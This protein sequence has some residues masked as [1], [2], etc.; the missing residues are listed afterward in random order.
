MN[1]E[2]KD[3]KQQEEVKEQEIVGPVEYRRLLSPC[4]IDVKDT[5]HF[6]VDDL[7]YALGHT[8]SRNIAITGHFGS[9][10]SSVANTCIDEMGICDEVLR[11][12]M[13][14]FA[15]APEER[16]NHDEIEYKIVQHL[17]YKCDASRIPD[18]GF[19]RL[20]RPEDRDYR[21]PIVM[22]LCALACCIIAFEPAMLRINS[23]YD[24]YYRLLGDLA[25]WWVNLIA[26]IASIGYLFYFLFRVCV[27][28]VPRFDKFKN[29]KIEAKG[30][31]LEASKNTEVSVF[32]K[33]LDEIIYIIQ[34]NQ[35]NYIL[36]E[37]LDRLKDSDKLFLKIRELN[38]LINESEA[39]KKRDRVVRFIYAIRDDVFTRELR[40]KCFDYI[41]A[42]VPVVDHYNVT[43]YLIKEYKRKGLFKTID[44]AVME[45]LLSKVSGLRELKNIVNEYT[46]F[47]KSLRAHIG[48]GSDKYEQ[49]MLAVI[50]YKNIFPQ[51]F[52]KAYKKEGLFYSVFREKKQFYEDKTKGL[53]ERLATA[54]Q[55]MNEM[56]EKI[57]NTRKQYLETLNDGRTI[58]KLIKNG[59]D[60]TLEQVANRDNL[61]ELFRNN[62]FDKYTYIEDDR[63]TVG[64]S[65]YDFVFKELENKIT[66]D[67]GYDEAV[68]VD[69]EKYTKA[70][71]DR[72]NLEKEI[73]VI[74]NTSLSEL[75][76]DIGSKKTTEILNGI[77]KKEY[78]Q[79]DE[80]APNKVNSD[81]VD[82]LQGMLYGGY[83]TEDYY[84]YISMFYEGAT[85]ES[86]YQFRSSI[87]HGKEWPY[88]YKLNNAKSVV[89]KLGVEDFKHKSILN[90]DV[91][92]YI[93]ESKQEHYIPSFVET[94]RKT[95]GFIVGYSQLA[96]FV[97][98]EFFTRVFAGWDSCVN[99]IRDQE[100]AE[101]TEEL[102]K[103]F[104]KE[105]PL[106]IR[107]TDD[108]KRYLNGR[109]QFI[110]AHIIDLSLDKLRQFVRHYG[111]CFDSLVVPNKDAQSFYDY[112]IESKR[113]VINKWNLG[114]VLGEDFNR[115][116][117][118]AILGLKND[119]VKAYV[120][121]DLEKLSALFPDTCKEEE[122]EGMA[123]L[124]KEAALI[125]P[126][127]ENYVADQE[128]IFETLDD[129]TPEGCSIL[130]SKDKVAI[131]WRNVYVAFRQFDKTVKDVLKDFV[132]RHVDELAPQVC[133]LPD[134]QT[135][136]LQEA[137][138]VTGIL[139]FDVFKKLINTF[140]LPYVYKDI[141]RIKDEER[142]GLLLENDRM[143]YD[144]ETLAFVFENCSQQLTASYFIRFY[145]EAMA[146]EEIDVNE[147][148]TNDFCVAIL[149]SGL[150]ADKKG[151]FLVSHARIDASGKEPSVLAGMILQFYLTHGFVAGIKKELLLSALQCYRG[152]KEWFLKI[153]LIN[154]YN[155]TMIYDRDFEEQ[156]IYS[157]R[158]E[159]YSKLNTTYG[160]AK[161][162]VNDENRTLLA[163]LKDKGHYVND[164]E[165][166]FD[167][168]EKKE[169][170][171]VSFKS[172]MP[173][174]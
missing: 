146:D 140:D 118:T 126:W 171:F 130:L 22:S 32:N 80:K 174:R 14:T 4:N 48:K 157:L 150:S 79:N 96:G 162:D 66:E 65:G 142:I 43:D 93:L 156:L 81:M 77:Y 23:F 60:Y 17:L 51:D 119:T 159:E 165:P 62:E 67:E 170:F 102:L 10:K 7:R 154:K 99:I 122:R 133:D 139:P 103:L 121:K 141:I 29:I 125:H 101:D 152:E 111:L 40:T 1:M 47:E 19:K 106:N 143:E 87:R 55:T 153:S 86:D 163:F 89:D 75:I 52:A 110:Q 28:F 25:G 3:I 30:V 72:I 98:D 104:F 5:S 90:Y 134:D 145:D 131:T 15:L 18:S 160:R 108:E 38:M 123:Y 8:D 166:R 95:P 45:Q 46:L 84:L 61:F 31:A 76:K 135:V 20:H 26:D 112:C 78:P 50:V 91:L 129:L 94:A 155:A 109:Y 132:I 35:Y 12:S 39:F 59:Y 6:A 149:N 2:E 21:K 148:V 83:I 100:R 53:R 138:M 42:V 69:Q 168:R 128:Y 161:F 97:N 167:E 34:A 169:K 173:E 120:V 107:L 58:I 82:A 85:S 11:I 137:L 117:M 37:D 73:K 136:E 56:R 124:L 63:E 151:L 54:T 68:F 74:E 158:R 71:E 88:D 44:A 116:P 16:Q 144:G 13:S 147:Y 24:A 41:V 70:N 127:L 9:G 164:F 105:C 172:F 27:Y 115:K 64:E 114:V 57:V 36:F 33:Y 92:N 49:K 113:F